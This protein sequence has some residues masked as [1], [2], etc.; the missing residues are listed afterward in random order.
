MSK[1]EATEPLD[2]PRDCHGTDQRRQKDVGVEVKVGVEGLGVLLDGLEPQL[3][4]QPSHAPSIGAIA[5][6]EL[7][8]QPEL[9]H[10]AMQRPMHRQESKESVQE[11]RFAPPLVDET[12]DRLGCA[13]ITANELKRDM[14]KLHKTGLG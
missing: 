5:P 13:N 1:T 14:K 11:V 4:D 7:R 3:L 10:L 6:E 12:P 8:E 9:L 2:L